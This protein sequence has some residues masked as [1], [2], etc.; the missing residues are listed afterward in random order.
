MLLWLMEAFIYVVELD[1]I[2][3]YGL[4]SLQAG[5]M[6]IR[7]YSRLFLHGL[8]EDKIASSQLSRIPVV[9]FKISQSST[10]KKI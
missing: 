5:W 1:F 7:S 3:K 4:L 8:W 9:F 2:V 6:I 10:S